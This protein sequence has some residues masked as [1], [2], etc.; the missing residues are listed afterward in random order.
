M[1]RQRDGIPALPV[2]AL[3]LEDDGI[4][5]ARLVPIV[6]A[7]HPGADIGERVERGRGATVVAVFV[8]LKNGPAGAAES[9]GRLSVS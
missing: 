3:L 5:E 6:D 4:G 2:H 1:R 8:D 7:R 9:A